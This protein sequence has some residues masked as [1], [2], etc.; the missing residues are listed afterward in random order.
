MTTLYRAFHD[1]IE[2]QKGEIILMKNDVI[3]FIK[4]VDYDW[5]HGLNISSGEKGLMPRT[6]VEPCLLPKIKYRDENFMDN[7]YLTISPY[8]S[9]HSEDLKFDSS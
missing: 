3:L 2:I 8:D 1:F 7:L 9:S 4:Q 6:F 5:F